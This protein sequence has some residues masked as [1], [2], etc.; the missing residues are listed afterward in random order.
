MPSDAFTNF[1]NTNPVPGGPPGAPPGA[2]PPFAQIPFGQF[3]LNNPLESILPNIPPR[4]DHGVFGPIL[5]GQ[6]PP[7]PPGFPPFPPPPTGNT[8]GFGGFVFGPPPGPPPPGGTPP[9][10]IPGTPPGTPPGPPPGLPLG[11]PPG[12]YQFHDAV[13][14]M[15]DFLAG[16]QFLPPGAGPPPPGQGP[17]GAPGF[18]F[19]DFASIAEFLPPS[20]LPPEAIA[21][22]FDN[23]G[24]GHPLIGAEGDVNPDL[25]TALNDHPPIPEGFDGFDFT[26]DFP[27]F[28]DMFT[29]YDAAH[30]GQPMTG[31]VNA[32][33]S[34]ALEDGTP[35]HCS[36]TTVVEA[37]LG[38][39]T[40]LILME[41][42]VCQIQWVVDLHQVTTT[43]VVVGDPADPTNMIEYDQTKDVLSQMTWTMLIEEVD[44]DGDG[45][46]DEI[47]TTGGNQVEVLDEQMETGKPDGLP[48]PPPPPELVLPFDFQGV[49]DLNQAETP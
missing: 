29:L 45:V 42:G 36:D 12:I 8:G 15:R 21:G 2:P 38:E 31:Q 47:H 40:P 27:Q 19:V 23:F 14:G 26:G 13:G 7:P 37:I 34:A 43:H 18:V 33:F 3:L 20:F 11:L 25:E 30:V 32:T 41:E 16:G 9:G 35:V 24:Q 39:A 46:A 22:I 10:G 28:D 6:V 48:D 44:T 1:L 5:F 17:E 49:L 4:F